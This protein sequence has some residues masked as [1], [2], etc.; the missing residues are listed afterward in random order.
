[1]AIAGF[2]L[3]D[4]YLANDLIVK[5]M[6][7]RLTLM[8]IKRY[9]GAVACVCKRGSGPA[10]IYKD[11]VFEQYISTSFKPVRVVATAEAITAVTFVDRMAQDVPNALTQ[12]CVTQL[13]DYFTG[14]RKH[15]L[16]PLAPVGTA[17]Q[18]KVWAR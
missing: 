11:A 14:H 13:I 15:F 12:S 16:L 7:T 17:Y 4:I 18:H 2:A 5:K 1:M 6:L 10:L 9:R 8:P 3:P